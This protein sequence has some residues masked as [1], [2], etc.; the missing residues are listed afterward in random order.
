MN[1]EYGYRDAPAADAASD[2]AASA[3]AAY[4]YAYAASVAAVYAYGLQDIRDAYRVNYA[5]LMECV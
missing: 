1:L 3:Y 4:A 5:V 2:Y